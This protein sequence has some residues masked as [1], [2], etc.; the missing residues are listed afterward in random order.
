MFELSLQCFD[1]ALRQP[2]Q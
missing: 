2:K 1:L